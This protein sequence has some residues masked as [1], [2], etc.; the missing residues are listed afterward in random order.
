MCPVWIIQTNILNQRDLF[1]HIAVWLTPVLTT[2]DKA[3]GQAVFNAKEYHNW[4]HKPL[5]DLSCKLGVF[6]S[7]VMFIFQFDRKEHETILHSPH[8]KQE[9]ANSVG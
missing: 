4:R 5:V 2:T 8:R 7:W 9:M 3:D 1:Q 6:A